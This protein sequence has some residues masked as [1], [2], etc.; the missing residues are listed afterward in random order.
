MVR[1]GTRCRS[2]GGSANLVNPIDEDQIMSQ[3]CSPLLL[4]PLLCLGLMPATALAQ[5]ESKGFYASI[6]GQYSQIGSST[7]S[8]L[9]PSGF[10]SGLRAE[11]GGGMGLGGD[12]GYRY[13]NGWAAE[14][15]WNYRSHSLDELRQGGAIRARDGDFA[16]NIVLVNG[17]RRFSTNSPWTPYV[18]A[19]VG[20]VQEIDIDIKPSAGGAERGY[21]KGSEFAAQFIAGVEYAIT[22]AWRLTADTRYMRVGSVRLDNETGNA[23]GSVSSLKYNPISVQVGVRYS[24]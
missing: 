10:G 4:G 2:G 18:G 19:G 14:I 15:E 9:G 21:S 5:A 22:P 23:G 7:F 20:W 16:S 12:I 6:Y 17:L 1:S 24:F 3:R 11:F 8:E 13:G